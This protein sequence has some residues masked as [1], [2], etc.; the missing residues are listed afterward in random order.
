M[1][2]PRP[3][4][5]LPEMSRAG[6]D[7]AHA[8]L[9]VDE[10]G[11][12]R[13]GAVPAER[14]LTLY[15]DR[16]EIVTLM[17]VGT[18][19]ELLALGYLR[20]QG[21]VDELDDILAVQVDWEVEAAAVTTRRGIGD[22]EEQLGRRTV[23]TGCGQ[24]T[25]FGSLMEK[26]EHTRLE[27]PLLPVAALHELAEAM[28]VRDT[29]YKHTGSIHGCAL[30]RRGEILCF[31]ED[32]GRHNAVDAIAGWMWLNGVDGADT[33]FY[34]T[35]RLTSEMVMKVARMGVPVLTSRS[36]TTQMG[37]DI[38]RRTGVTLVGRLRGR[39]FLVYHGAE[40]IAFASA[41]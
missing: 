4:Q 27:A 3:P 35:G 7:A 10:N 13:A 29:L 15:V 19:P 32:V 5:H 31:Y 16:R 9:A 41:P 23:T 37:L 34:T 28:R 39:H 22:W 8:V 11:H 24:G 1:P 18:Q 33:L 2:A 36:G 17:T 14:P 40:R 6:V 25:V 20:N 21:L 26:I 12:V 30:A 38:A